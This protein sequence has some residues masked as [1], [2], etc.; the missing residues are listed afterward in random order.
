M[1]KKEATN[2]SVFDVLFFCV[3]S[4]STGLLF[5]AERDSTREKVTWKNFSKYFHFV[6]FV[7]YAE[8]YARSI[9]DMDMNVRDTKINNKLKSRAQPICELIEPPRIEPAA[10]YAPNPPAENAI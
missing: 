4:I 10:Q 2:D 1:G 6:G 8:L 3:S 9:L 5:G 7:R